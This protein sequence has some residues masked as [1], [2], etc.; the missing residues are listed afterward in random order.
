MNDFQKRYGPWAV[1][2]GASDGTGAAFAEQLAA[3]GVNVVLVARRRALLEDLAARLPT[4]A[5]VVVL[6][7]ATPDAGAVLAA[8]TEDLD[9]GLVVYNAGADPHSLP[10]LEQ[11]LTDLRS[12]VARNC[13]TVVDTCHHFGKRLVARGRGG[14]VLVSSAAAW[15]GAGYIAAYGATKSFDL[16]LAEALWA[17]WRPHGVD[18]LALVLGA[19]DTPSLRA[20]L[21]KRGGTFPDIAKAEDVVRE[22]L[23]HLADGPTWSIGMPDP[24]GPSPLAT[25]PR[26]QASELLTEHASAAHRAA[27][28]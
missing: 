10:F 24:R 18:V 3:R 5:R 19:T 7:L 16:I 28:S 9:V 4:E 13:A 12:L 15:V 1:V 2:A 17:E 8:A 25:L 11:P 6:D 27:Q 26:R 21:A 22:G 23:D 20:M 14:V